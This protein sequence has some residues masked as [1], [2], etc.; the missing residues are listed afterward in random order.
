MKTYFSQVNKKGINGCNQS[1]C[2]YPDVD[3]AKQP[4]AHSVEL[5]VP[6]FIHLEELPEED[7]SPTSA[8]D[9]LM[10]KVTVILKEPQQFHKFIEPQLNNLIKGT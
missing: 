7:E 4:V 5:H 3:S 8:I 6:S 1:K 9:S 2:T 10:G